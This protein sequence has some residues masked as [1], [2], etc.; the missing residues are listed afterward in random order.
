MMPMSTINK[1]KTT[2][3]QVKKQVQ[4]VSEAQ[5]KNIMDSL[6]EDELDNVEELEEAN[7]ANM[8]QLREEMDKPCAFNKEDQLLSKY[9]VMPVKKEELTTS[10]KR[11][12]DEISN[13]HSEKKE[14]LVKQQSN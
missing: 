14:V 4:K 5:S 13:T 8:A 7:G 9:N 2:T 1:K 3:T 11:K 10:K 6:L 12:I